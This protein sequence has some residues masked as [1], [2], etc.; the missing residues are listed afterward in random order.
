MPDRKGF[1]ESYDLPLLL[2]F[3]ACVK[4][5]RAEV[6]APVRSH[7]TY[8]ILPD[9]VKR[10]RRPDVLILQGINM[11]EA[12]LPESSEGHPVFVSDHVDFSIYAD[13]KERYHSAYFHRFADLPIEEAKGC[14]LRIWGEIDHLK[15]NIEP[16]RDRA[17]LILEKGPDHSARGV[18]L[19][20]L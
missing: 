16:T 19:R 4:A 14:A 6:D 5:G 20:M 12:G 18:R 2:R 3:L 17:R 11:L 9:E 10:I 1:P 7:L 15:W 8:D 13:A